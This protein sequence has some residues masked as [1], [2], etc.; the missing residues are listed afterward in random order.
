MS[1]NYD[2]FMLDYAAGNQSPAM[3]L[4]GDLHTWL[5]RSGLEAASIWSIIG[6]VMLE[7]GPSAPAQKVD[8]TGRKRAAPSVG[9]Q[10]VLDTS[11]EDLK[12]K[13]GWSGVH[14]ARVGIKD[15]SYMALLPGQSAPSHDH[16]VLEATVV[17]SGRFT[18]GHGEYT[19]G[20]IVIGAPGLVHQPAAVG[21]AR[22]VC[23]VAREPRA[24]W[25]FS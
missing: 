17:L 12:W 25:R 11:F 19:R 3:T 8:A 14:Y 16:S 2:A 15:A 20:D 13:R 9:V 4:A 21:D 7:R 5:N 24:F 6:G 1:G 18:D 10:D 23:Y 22:C